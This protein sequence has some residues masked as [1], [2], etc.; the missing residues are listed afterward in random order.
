M[1][2]PARILIE[3]RPRLGIDVAALPCG[4]RVAEIDVAFAVILHAAMLGGWREMG[5]RAEMRQ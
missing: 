3:Q 2:E 4:A 1:Q 5:K